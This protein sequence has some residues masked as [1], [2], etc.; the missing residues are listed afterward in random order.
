[1]SKINR[2]VQHRPKGEEQKARE[3]VDLKQENHSLKRKLKR[4]EKEVRKR[5]TIEEDAIAIET[6]EE[7]AV[8]ECPECGSRIKNL[9]LAGKSFN[10][11]G[12][13]KW[14]KKA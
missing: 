14:R 9:T 3:M 7:P 8:E 4:L 6:P 1:L 2:A 12:E 5:T 13:C 10:I 11:C